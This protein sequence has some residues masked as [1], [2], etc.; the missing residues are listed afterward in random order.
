ME[1]RPGGGFSGPA[2]DPGRWVRKMGLVAP[3]NL[4]KY[5]SCCNSWLNH[6]LTAAYGAHFKRVGPPN[7]GQI[8]SVIADESRPDEFNAGWTDGSEIEKAVADVRH[9]FPAPN[10]AL[11]DFRAKLASA[12]T[13]DGWTG[14]HV[15]YIVRTKKG[16]S[17]GT[18]EVVARKRD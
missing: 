13:L 7:P 8:L 5:C 3:R 14:T 9:F 1:K 10:S 16:V 2:W 4:G 11:E 15:V 12:T 6:T 18:S 17:V